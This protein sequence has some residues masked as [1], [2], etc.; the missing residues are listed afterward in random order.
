M[1]ADNDKEASN[2]LSPNTAPG[3][4]VAG[5]GSANSAG[6]SKRVRRPKACKQCHAL[7][8]RCTPLNENDPYLPCVRCSNSGK[9]CEI[10]VDQPRKRRRRA[11]GNETVAELQD[12]IAELKEQL[13]QLNA[14]LQQLQQQAQ[15]SQIKPPISPSAALNG[16]PRVGVAAH[17]DTPTDEDLPFFVSKA[18]LEREM[19]LLTEGG[20]HLSDIM[21][22]IQER[23]D[24]RRSQFQ[25]KRVKDV[26]SAGIISKEEAAARLNIYRTEVYSRY[27]FVEIPEL[28]SVD[29]F[30]ETLPFLFN[31][32]VS[33]ASLVINLSTDQKQCLLVDIFAMEAVCNEVLV[34]GSKSVELI[35]SLILLSLWYN[36]PELFKQRRYHIL[37]TVAVSLLHDLGIVSRPSYA[38]LTENRTIVKLQEEHTSIEYRALIMI[39]YISTVGFCLILRRNIYVK[40]TPYVNECCSLLEKEGNERYNDLATFLRLNHELERIHHI[41]H[42]PE[43]SENRAKVSKYV[44]SEFQV[45][46][47]SLFGRINPVNYLGR[48]Y[49]FSVEA[50][51]HQPD[52]NSVQIINEDG[53]GCALKLNS[54]TLKSISQC[55]VSCLRALDE[56]A[57]LKPADIAALPLVYS[58]RIIYTAGMLLRMRYLILSLPSYIEKDLVPRYAILSIQ[59]LKKLLQVSSET[60]P[61]NNFLLKMRLILQLFIQTYVTQVLDLLQSHNETP[62]QFRPV[63]KDFSKNER[64]QMALLA[65]DMYNIGGGG[66]MTVDSGRYN[67]PAMH[68]DLLSYAASFRRQSDDG[69]KASDDHKKENGMKGG[70]AIPPS[71]H[72]SEFR[73]PVG[74]VGP[75]VPQPNF[76]LRPM[77]P[78]DPNS[79]SASTPYTRGVGGVPLPIPTYMQQSYLFP[80]LNKLSTT[81]YDSSRMALNGSPNPSQNDGMGYQNP[82]LDLNLGEILGKDPFHSINEEF[83]LNLLSADS[84]KIHFAQDIPGPNDEIFFMN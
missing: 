34:W 8:V 10:E 9:V 81:V 29:E 13:R 23:N 33:I 26:V 71:L 84:N 16:T 36:P 52:F 53:T 59:R 56:V 46:L 2:H 63:S 65:T 74:G 17:Q 30:I 58:S 37:N 78:G 49:Y 14:Q 32:V 22:I 60:Y 51:L 67:A 64:R 50:Y 45:I 61:A 11:A 19:T 18:D 15:Q 54:A 62:S 76:L 80:E 4:S 48:A 21:N 24:F 27:P 6:T 47:G 66:M 25:T 31:T 43:A 7:K 39:L 20:C 82:S 41:V 38:Y 79:V 57:K 70:E 75:K 44:I 72:N 3:N 55:T 28:I 5:S 69:G 77:N 83:W 42:S 40:W 68:L 35:K 1:P 73:D 12:Q